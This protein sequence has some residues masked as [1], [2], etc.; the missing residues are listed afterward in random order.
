MKI[1]ALE[2]F[3]MVLSKGSFAA[4]AKE[5]GLTPGAVSLQMA[6]LE[7][8]FGR[9]I[10]D[11]SART[12][13]PTA[14][15]EGLGLSVRDALAAIESFRAGPE[16]LGVS[17]RLTL[18]AIPSV[19]SS[20]LPPALRL[21]QEKHPALS[22]ELTLDV[23]TPLQGALTAGRIDAAVMVRPHGGGSTR[24]VWR[25]LADERFVLVA[26]ALATGRSVSQL[27][28]E[29]PW[30][31]YDVALTGGRVAA[32]YVR[33]VHPDKRP[34]FDVASTDAIVAMISEGLGVS[35]IPQPR[36]RLRE[37]YG[38]R[39]IS[40]GA[41]GPFRRISLVCRKPDAEDRRIAALHAALQE[42][43]GTRAAA[44]T[45]GRT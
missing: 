34:L 29:Y 37:A 40:L 44:H 43:C 16:L 35:V 10:F 36:S 13:R 28:R 31:R 20:M 4:A 14:F 42:C 8:Y 33:K 19:Q 9:P 15:A 39:E 25:D 7:A 22:I 11:R 32:Q 45:R 23:S 24:L 1:R 2:T 38:V 41:A 26:P 3:M 18:G 21:L 30:I 17:G 12:V 6:Q 27:L 5:V